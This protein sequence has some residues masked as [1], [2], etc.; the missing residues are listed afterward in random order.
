[1]KVVIFN[2]LNF[3]EVVHSGEV[4][5]SPSLTQP[6]E[7]LSIREILANHVRG[8]P[9]NGSEGVYLQGDDDDPDYF[10]DVSGLDLVE[11]EEYR[12][13]Y[14]KEAKRLKKALSTPPPVP[15]APVEPPTPTPPIPPPATPEV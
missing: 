13:Y 8:L 2:W 6:D 4:S 5:T 11:I 3:K 10:P 7:V 15:P 12:D 1:M 9:M 14:A